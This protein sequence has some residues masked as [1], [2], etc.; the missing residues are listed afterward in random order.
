[1]MLYKAEQLAT[2]KI[3]ALQGIGNYIFISTQQK[4]LTILPRE[5]Y[6]FIAVYIWRHNDSKWSSKHVK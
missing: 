6:G 2:N 3:K 5:F 1:M 4:V